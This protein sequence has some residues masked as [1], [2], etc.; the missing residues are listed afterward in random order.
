MTEEQSRGKPHHNE[1]DV[2][3]LELGLSWR[4][5]GPEGVTQRGGGGM[6]WAANAMDFEGIES[7]YQGGRGCSMQIEVRNFHTFAHRCGGGGGGVGWGGGGGGGG[8]GASN[9]EQ[10]NQSQK[11]TRIG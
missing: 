10:F 3:R 4:R 11:P 7:L 1:K 2:T 8:G 6:G 9:F 5:Q